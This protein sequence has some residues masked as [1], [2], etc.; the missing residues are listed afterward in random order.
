MTDQLPPASFTPELR[1]QQYKL[2]VESAERGSDRRAHTQAFY[3]TIHTSLL[4]LLAL[5][6]GYGLLISGSGGKGAS[7][8]GTGFLAQ[9]Q[10]PIIVAV[11]AIGVILCVLWYV[12]LEAYR[13]LNAA[14]VAVIHVMEQD[15]P[16]QPFQMEWTALKK[17]RH[18][19]LTTLERFM[20]LVVGLLYVI[21]V[22]TYAI[23]V[24][25]AH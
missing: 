5:V 18:I 8:A 6:G 20:P 10:G 13:R 3:I 19:E 21:L 4:T 14:K 12:H 17:H 24:H 11:S 7:P 1:F 22:G 15:L 16:Y 9:A 25:F 2:I 23:V